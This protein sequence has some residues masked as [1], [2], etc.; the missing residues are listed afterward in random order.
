MVKA[1]EDVQGSLT[2]SA[3]G[4]QVLEQMV[5]DQEPELGGI[6]RRDR[7]EVAAG[8]PDSSAGERVDMGME[9]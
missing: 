5:A 9:I 3:A 7:L 1:V 2:D 6:E 4:E 8:R